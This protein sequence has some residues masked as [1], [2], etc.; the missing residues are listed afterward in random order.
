MAGFIKDGSSSTA[1]SEINVTP[2]VDV[3]LVLLIVFMISAPM[4]SQ[5][6]QV[7]LPKTQ[8][9]TLNDSQD[10]VIL[11]VNKNRQILINDKAIEQ[12][13]LRSKLQAIASAKPNVEVFIQADQGLPYGVIATVMAE[14]KKAKIQRVGLVTEP[15]D[16]KLKL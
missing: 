15:G 13:S 11:V 10:P 16:S 5:G 12:G 6:I 7:D 9:Q 14:V 1:L 8:A 4:M 3:M 2:L